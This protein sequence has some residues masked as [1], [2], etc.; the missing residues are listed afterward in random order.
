MGSAA[1]YYRLLYNLLSV[2]LLAVI[3]VWLPPRGN[4]LYDVPPPWNWLMYAVQLGAATA[5]VLT[6]REFSLREFLGIASV[7]SDGSDPAERLSFKGAFQYCRHPLY[8]SSAVFMLAQPTMT[9][10]A[11]AWSLNI[12]LYFFIGSYFEERN[13]ETRFGQVYRDYQMR[14]PRFIPRLRRGK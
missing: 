12:V 7:G 9:D 6:L 1:V 2:L 14:V 13:L 3:Y 11:L 8:T 4:V 10:G 5:F